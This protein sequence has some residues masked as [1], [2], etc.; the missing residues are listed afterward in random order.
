MATT[1]EEQKFRILQALSCGEE[2]P[3]HKLYAMTRLGGIQ[4]TPTVLKQMA[5]DGLV[6]RYRPRH[7]Q[8]AGFGSIPTLNSITKQGL[9]ELAAMGRIGDGHE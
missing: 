3:T 6:N 9:D 8:Q 2:M 1:I 7:K 4:S 5:A